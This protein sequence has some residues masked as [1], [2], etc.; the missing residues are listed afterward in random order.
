MINPERKRE[1]L[2]WLVDEAQ[3]SSTN[4]PPIFPVLSLSAG[5]IDA[6]PPFDASPEDVSE[7]KASFT[8]QFLK[9]MFETTPRKKA[10]V[11]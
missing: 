1:I 9:E 4:Q 7:A 8:G 6:T 2:G 11:G 10:A 3:T 5:T